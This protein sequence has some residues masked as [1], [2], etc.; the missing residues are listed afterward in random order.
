MTEGNGRLHGQTVLITGATSGIGEVAAHQLAGMGARVVIVAR[1]P[2][3]GA[4]TMASI[5][6][7]TG[8]QAV[9]LLLADLSAQADIRRL[10][11]EFKAGHDRL[12]VLVNNAGVF[13]L[14]RELSR[15]GIEMTWATNH[16]NYF[17][18]TNLLL[19]VLKASAPARIVNVSSD[20][21]RGGSIR[22]D[23]LGGAEK[24]SS[25][26]AY[27][28]SKL[29][30]VLFSYELARRLTG[31]GVTVNALHP[32]FVRTNFAR[33]NG[34]F[35]RLLVPIFQLAAI[36]PEKGAETMVYLASSP[37]VAGVSGSYFDKK[38]AVR[39]AEAS[40]DEAVARQLWEA[41]AQMVGLE[42]AV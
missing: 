18:L 25:W 39:S 24:Y 42:T 20:A 17:L 1:S 29:A 27:S 34:R 4:Q 6:K 19:D 13:N 30:N 36:S 14:S 32:G 35:S 3:K 15:D 12:D 37:E 28:Q 8:S 40:Y 33:N 9:E 31:S 38:K 23:D 11:A 7:T 2:E 10:A 41:S 22:F 16:L 26:Q 5:Q 21:H